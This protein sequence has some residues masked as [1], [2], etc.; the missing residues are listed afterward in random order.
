[1]DITVADATPSSARSRV[2]PP[3]PE[4]GTCRALHPCM[5]KGNVNSTPRVG[6]IQLTVAECIERVLVEHGIN[7]AATI[8]GGPLMPLLRAFHEKGRIKSL[9]TRHESSAAM[10]AEGYQRVS[11]T[12]AVVAL[13][14]GPGVSNAATGVALAM[15]EQTPLVVISAQV[16]TSWY[17][18][19]AAQEL[20]T[21]RLLEPITKASATLIDPSRTQAVLEYLIRVA[22]TGRGG[23]VHLSVPSNVWAERCLFH[24][25]KPS[26]KEASREPSAGAGKGV[27]PQL[28]QVRTSDGLGD[29]MERIE[30]AQSPCVLAGRGVVLAGAEL[31]LLALAE[32]FPKLRVACTPRSKGAFPE[33]HAQSLGV[34]GFAGHA[35]AEQTLLEDSDLVIVLGSRLGEITSLGWDE[36]FRNVDLV[37]IDI[38]PAE[39]GRNFPIQH[40]VAGDIRWALRALLGDASTAPRVSPSRGEQPTQ[41]EPDE[42]S[43]QT[44]LQTTTLDAST[45]AATAASSDGLPP[46]RVMHALNQVLSGDEHV[47][48]DIGNCMAWA[49]HH[50]RR[51]VSGRWHVNLMY[52]CMGHALPAAVGGALAAREPVVVVVGDAAFAMCGFELH[53][54]VEND[55]PVIVVVLN[56]SGH[57]MVVMGSEWQFGPNAVP[58]AR[59]RHPIDARA[60]ASSVGVRAACVS[61]EQSLEDE[62]RSALASRKPR[63]IDV[64]ID[65]NEVPPFGSR[66]DLLKKNFTAPSSAQTQAGADHG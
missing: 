51:N 29:V 23:P 18:R 28:V 14:A 4:V 59:F 63:L 3:S 13:T 15:A 20:D 32:R 56:D 58:D 16:A 66:M 17:G 8:P 52:G 41:R 21:L 19:G 55:L 37:Q 35:R 43:V 64:R 1:M 49:I 6:V 2:K 42:G 33:G 25:R 26:V 60:M 36:R 50:L 65:P 10:L 53:T 44:T 24:I 54:A 39:L 57:G 30:R 22:T 47:F 61:T 62:L 40:G 9:I 48:I 11:K 27:A 31:E 5:A 38:E 45:A 7:V 34:F 12:P 46:S